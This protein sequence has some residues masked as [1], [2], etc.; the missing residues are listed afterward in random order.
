MS[1]VCVIGLGYVGYP[2]AV[3]AK[4]K[5]HAVS[6][7]DIDKGVVRAIERG[8]DPLT[9]KRSGVSF[10]IAMDGTASIPAADVVLICVPTPVNKHKLPDLGPV[11]NAT[12]MV[13]A[14]LKPKSRSLVVVESTINPGVMEDVVKP[15]FDGQGLVIG[16]DYYLAHCPERINPG[17]P[18]W[19]VSNIPRVLGAF[20]KRGLGKAHTFYTGL[21]D[22]PITR[23]SNIRTAEA[24]KVVENAF[25]DINIAYVNELAKSFEKLDIDVVE[26]IDGAKTKPFAFMP[27]Y[28][29]CGVGGHCIPVD[30]YY[31]IEKA[32]TEGFDHQ[33][34]KL[35]REINESMPKH[36]IDLLADALEEQK[37]SINGTTV[38]V[39]G[40]SYKPNVGD[41]RESPSYVITDELKKKGADVVTYDPYFDTDCKDLK[42]FQERCDV[43]VLCTNHKAYEQLD[44]NEVMVLV[45][46]KNMFYGKQIPASCTYRGIGR[47]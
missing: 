45:D 30:P 11:K 13:A 10:P 47:H 33:F 36:T 19:D 40:L 37:K 35:A 1:N 3:L 41:D 24:C 21:V 16:K 8:D 39:L 18:R 14:H 12:A 25:R 22:A 46:G 15:L 20:T 5:G 28:P 38:G 29:S 31:L 32:K 4:K 26:V 7:I 44:L 17:D 42:E 27:H 2:L 9:G 34:L 23:M 43:V 6:G